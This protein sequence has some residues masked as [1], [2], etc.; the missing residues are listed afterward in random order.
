MPKEENMRKNK[1]VS[2][3]VLVSLVSVTSILFCLSKPAPLE[4]QEKK[5]IRL[6]V[7]SLSWNTQ[8]PIRV[9]M[10]KGYFKD[11]GLAVEPIF[12]RGG[13]AAMAALISGD[14]DFGSIGGAQA[15][16][17]ARARGSDI[18]IIGSISNYIDYLVIGS[19]GT[20]NVAELK[21]KTIGIT[22][23]GAFSE[24]AMR[25]FFK[26]SNLDPDKDVILRAVGNT[27]MR[28]A[29]LEKGLIT[30]APFSPQDAVRLIDEG[31][32]LIANMSESLAIPENMFIARDE[33][34]EKYPETSKR[35]L[36]ALVLGIHL[37]KKNK[38]EAIQAGYAAGLKGDSDTVNKA[39]DLYVAGFTSDL[40]IAVDGIQ[41]ILEEEIH[42]GIVD[43]KMTVDRV[44]NDRILK[45]AQ[46]ELKSEGRLAP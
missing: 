35:F 25:L 23:A 24:F 30:A 19:K 45:L 3:V 34:L 11:E 46:E 12:I 2:S 8:L 31:F 21:G 33:V 5:N 42:S 1:L 43:R 18:S 44:I 22:G 26:K 40:A 16:I 28:A 27:T 32:P 17:R 36:K 7:V 38:K 20:K 37:T 15:V 9:A 6:V 13:P 39:Y 41:R 14:A 29:A 4:A 10:A